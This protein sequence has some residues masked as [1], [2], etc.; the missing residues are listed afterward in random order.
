MLIPRQVEATLNRGPRTGQGEVTVLTVKFTTANELNA[1]S[2]FN[3]ELPEG[4]YT[5]I[6]NTDITVR[7]SLGTSV[8]VNSNADLST[9]SFNFLLA[10]PVP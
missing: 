1:N 8:F 3:V 9:N 2:K 6:D 4:M 7:H 10:D 5:R